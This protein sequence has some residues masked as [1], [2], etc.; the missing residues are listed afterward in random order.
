MTAPD[1]ELNRLDSPV[2][3]AI[4]R[5]SRLPRTNRRPS[6][7]SRTNEASDALTGFGGRALIEATHDADHRKLSASIATANGALSAW[8]S[9]PPIVGPATCATDSLAWSF[10]FPS[11]ST[12][13]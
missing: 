11:T 12:S 5:R 2:H 4:D 9:R 7:I 8:M 13:R 1:I 6:P 10:A 3:I